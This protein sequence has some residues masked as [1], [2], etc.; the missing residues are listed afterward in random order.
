MDEPV[1]TIR[2]TLVLRR[3]ELEHNVARFY[4]LMIERGLFERTVLVRHW[5]RISGRG[6][7]QTGGARQRGRSNRGSGEA[8]RRQAPVRIPGHVVHPQH[9]ALA[10]RGQQIGCTSSAGYVPGDRCVSKSLFKW[11]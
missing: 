5:G 3:L 9:P 4:A 8:G 2:H 7:E 1:S 11:T 10:A 6:R